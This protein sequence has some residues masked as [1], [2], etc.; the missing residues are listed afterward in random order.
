MSFSQ[1]QNFNEDPNNFNQNEQGNT[2]HQPYPVQVPQMRTRVYPT[3]SKIKWRD[4]MKIDL[5]MIAR[6]NDLSVLEYYLENIVYSDITEDE[7]QSVPEGNIVRLIKVCQF[8][9]EYLLSTQQKLEA[10]FRNL[11]AQSNQLNIDNINKDHQLKDNKDLIRI[12]KKEKQHNETVLMTYKNVIEN[13]HHKRANK[14]SSVYNSQSESID[15]SKQRFYCKYCKGKK[16]STEELLNNH[17]HKRHL[18]K[19]PS[20]AVHREDSKGND[21]QMNVF[22]KKLEEMKTHFEV[23]FKKFQEDTSLKQLD[24]QRK[25]EEDKQN[26]QLVD[27]GNTFKNTLN[28]L[29]DF[30]LQNALKN[31]QQ[32]QI[33][34]GSM[35]VVPSNDQIQMPMPVPVPIANN[36]ND[37]MAQ[38]LKEELTKLNEG[39]MHIS[40]QQ[41]QKLNSLSDKL[42]NLR[43]SEQIEKS[44][45]DS[46]RDINPIKERKKE[47][48]ESLAIA[49]QH[50]TTY[51]KSTLNK[52]LQK[53]KG[54]FNAG[55][56][57]S[58]SDSGKDKKKKKKKKK[59]SK[60]DHLIEG[61]KDATNTFNEIVNKSKLKQSIHEP[62][63]EKQLSI[64]EKSKK[65]IESPKSLKEQDSIHNID[66]KETFGV[67]AQTMNNPRIKAELIDEFNAFEKNYNQRDHEF[68]NQPKEDIYLMQTL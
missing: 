16:Y 27:M 39:L 66:P 51:I 29:K 65:K 34:V 7:V 45:Q 46:Q 22:E 61:L 4:I 20:S 50:S 21:G 30:Y 18:I 48:E 28:E 44:H 35:S 57:E 60:D 58:D 3:T 37:Q 6:T 64:E 17:L 56:I 26:N 12:L 32:Q 62:E 5:D 41:D 36:Q 15:E 9:I 59:D 14:H 33:H 10:N 23:Y 67:S 8:T 31:N 43:R 24:I 11:E 19:V 63:N 47:R 68:I 25:M 40:S 53:R 13:N 54:Q 1:S 49:P 55:P 2:L 42:N 38:M 52:P